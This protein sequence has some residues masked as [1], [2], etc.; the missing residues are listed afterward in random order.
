MEVSNT[1]PPN[2]EQILL[3]FPQAANKGVI[4]TYGNTI[5]NPTGGPVSDELKAH[6]AIHCARQGNDIAGWWD[7]YLSDPEFR[8]DEELPAHRAEYRR[9]LFTHRDRE[10]CNAY[11]LRISERL[12]SPLYGHLVSPNQARRMIAK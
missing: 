2:Y 6:E 1:H 7:R 8:L 4:F 3:V 9:F 10:E 11:L 12:A 5:Y